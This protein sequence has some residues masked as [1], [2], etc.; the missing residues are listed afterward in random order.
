MN[1][2]RILGILFLATGLMVGGCGGTDVEAD[3]QE[4]S[5][6]RQDAIWACRLG[7]SRY[8]EFFRDAS[9]TQWAGTYDCNCQGELTMIGNW[10]TYSTPTAPQICY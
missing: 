1:A 6:S 10:T 9:Q 5:G 4:E 8:V 3:T 2:K 7:E